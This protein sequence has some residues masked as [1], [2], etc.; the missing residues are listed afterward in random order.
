MELLFRENLLLGMKIMDM[1]F[2][3][4]EKMEDSLMSLGE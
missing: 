4:E 2:L 3:L 1:I